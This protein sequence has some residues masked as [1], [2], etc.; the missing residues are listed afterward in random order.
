M[1]NQAAFYV[2]QNA[3][4]EV[5][6]APM[7]TPGPGQLVIKNGAVAVNPVDW[8]LQDY[9][10]FGLALPMILGEDVAGEVAAVGAGVTAFKQGDR[11]TAYPLALASRD[12]LD[13]GFQ[14]YS[15]VN[16]SVTAKIPDSLD[17]AAASAIPLALATATHGLYDG[18]FL[19]LP[20]PSLSPKPAGKVLLI[21]GASSSVGAMAVQLAK[22]SGLEV[23]ATGSK[24]NHDF[25]RSLG[26]DA[27]F[28]YSAPSVVADIVAYGK[29]KTFAGVYDAVSYPESQQKSA[30][31]LA[32]SQGS[33]FVAATQGAETGLP[34]GVTAV[35]CMAF[36]IKDT[37]AGNTVWHDFLPAAL[38][39][40]SF[41][42]APRAHVVGKGLQHV[43]AGLD[44]N[45]KGVSAA[46]VVITL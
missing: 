45:K 35:Q 21:W 41:K 40:G 5:R 33:K 16:A 1:A 38:A 27:V 11:V 29:G 13:A 7:P 14:L 23:V 15:R 31:V 22:A 25:I 44:M 2:A 10:F 28:D 24:H 18:K 46:K 42:A 26:A 3:P 36:M 19:A 4:F 12:P 6:D 17:Y 43:Q 30:Q 34:G 39:N 32:Q 20:L 8:K 37:E 9:D